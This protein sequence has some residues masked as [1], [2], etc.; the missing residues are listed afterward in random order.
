MLM[1]SALRGYLADVAG[2]FAKWFEV[3]AMSPSSD[4]EQYIDL[5]SSQLIV[6]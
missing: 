2:K 6:I 5:V 1:V 3:A 4:L